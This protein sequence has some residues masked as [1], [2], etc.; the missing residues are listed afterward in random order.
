MPRY[1]VFAVLVVLLLVIPFSSSTAQ[2][3]DEGAVC[4]NIDRAQV[5]LLVKKAADEEA[6]A[7]AELEA[8]QPAAVLLIVDVSGSMLDVT[9][10]G[11]ERM[12]VAKEVLAGYVTDL[13]DDAHVGLRLLGGSCTTDLRYPIAILDKPKMLDVIDDLQPDGS[14]PL[15]FAIAAAGSDLS[16]IEGVR[17]IVLVTDGEETCNGDPVQAAADLAASDPN[18]N[19][20]IHVVGFNVIQDVSAQDNLRLIPR[21]AGGV[22]IPAENEEDLAQALTVTTRIP[23]MIYDDASNLVDDGLANRSSL[24]LL[25]GTYTVEVPLLGI[26][27]SVTVEKGVGSALNIDAD[28]AV[29][30]VENDPLCIA[31]FCPAVPLP[32]LVVGQRGRVTLHDPRSSRV[33][34]GPGTSASVVT[35][36]EPGTE[37]DVLGGPVCADGYLWYNIR[38]DSFEGWSAE[39]LPGNYYLETYP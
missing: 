1:L 3:N 21:A 32:Q 9:E 34:S 16:G 28:G 19:I 13:P 29:S 38:G 24:A 8:I 31:E 11:R 6:A 37:F 4:V 30:V 36:I 5:D 39:G 26:M 12:E 25:P 22:F 15:A 10:D 14:T 35:N 2:T 27:Q 20:T 18:L 23:F 17:E 33:R 7:Q